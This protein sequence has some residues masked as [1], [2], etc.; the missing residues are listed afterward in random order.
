M[1]TFAVTIFLFVDSG[2]DTGTTGAS[3]KGNAEV[4]EVP[5]PPLAGDAAERHGYGNTTHAG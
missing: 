1:S 2:A 3:E 5:Q 4:P